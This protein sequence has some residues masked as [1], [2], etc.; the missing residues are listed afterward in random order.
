MASTR[1]NNMP[2]DYCLQQNIHKNTNNY[3]FYINSQSGLPY[4]T[5]IPDLGYMPS[6]MSSNAFSNNPIDIES[7]LFGINSSNLVSPQSAVIPELKTLNTINFFDRLET[8]M[9]VPL[10]VEPKQRP[11]PVPN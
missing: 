1:N 9:P 5:A 2:G 10:V 6:H 11:F 8:I 4:T 7:A 3:N